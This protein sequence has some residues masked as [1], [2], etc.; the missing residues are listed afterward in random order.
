MAGY[1]I[2]IEEKSLGNDFIRE[3]LFSAP[4]VQPVVMSLAPG[5]EIGL[6]THMDVDQFIRV[7]AGKGKAV[8]NGEDRRARTERPRYATAHGVGAA[9]GSF[10]KET[11]G[12]E[13]R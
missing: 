8:P 4:R 6:E 11:Y 13:I 1:V 7:E 10:E 5:E 9:N 2:N 12:T 3:V